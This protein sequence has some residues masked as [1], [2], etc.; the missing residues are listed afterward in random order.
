[1]FHVKHQTLYHVTP[2]K[3]VGKIK[4]RGIAPMQ[5]TN[6]VQSGSGA[7]YGNIGEIFAF[8]HPA[9][10]IQWAAKMDWSLFKS[11][12]S[13]KISV[14]VFEADMDAWEEDTADPIGQAGRRGRWLK[15]R[16]GVRPEQVVRA[17]KVTLLSI[18]N[19]LRR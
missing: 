19:A 6:W 1:M 7:R 4:K 17:D 15:S 8:E 5:P 11:M 14:V 16:V 18:Q 3:N 10:A 12:G 9:D 13:G 2:T